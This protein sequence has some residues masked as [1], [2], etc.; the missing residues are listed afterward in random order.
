MPP[1]GRSNA[2]N[3]KYKL[4]GLYQTNVGIMNA[5]NDKIKQQHNFINEK[6]SVIN[7]MQWVYTWK[8]LFKSQLDVEL[9]EISI[10]INSKQIKL[11]HKKQLLEQVERKS[12]VLVEEIKNKKWKIWYQNFIMCI[13]KQ[14]T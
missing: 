9:K 6:Q 4:L 14:K 2:Q 1:K 11:D 5:M 13:K 10:A 8:W 12:T 3:S 7:E